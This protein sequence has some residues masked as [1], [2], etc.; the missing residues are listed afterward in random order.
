[1]KPLALMRWLVRL[2]CPAGGLVCDPFLGSAT[3]ALAC[4]AEGRRCVG[5]EN[6]H[7]HFDIAVARVER[8]LAERR[9]QAPLFAGAADA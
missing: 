8:A 2:V 1:M 3:T 4:L 9:D 7:G 6:D 5:V